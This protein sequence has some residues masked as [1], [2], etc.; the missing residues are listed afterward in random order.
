MR[1]HKLNSSLR[2]N[3]SLRLDASTGLSLLELGLVMA[4]VALALVPMVKSIGGPMSPNGKGSAA[5]TTGFKNKE[6]I[7]ATNL[8]NQV[9]SGDYSSFNCLPAGTGTN[10]ALP[11]SVRSYNR[12]EATQDNLTYQWSAM[13]INQANSGNKPPDGYSFFKGVLNIYE[14]GASPTNEPL[15]SM[16]VNFYKFTGLANQPQQK[17]GVLIALDRSGSMANSATKEGMPPNISGDQKTQKSLSF[18]LPFLWYRYKPFPTP[19]TVTDWGYDFP[20]ISDP[21][22][23]PLDMWNNAT[24]D[25]VSLQNM[26]GQNGSDPNPA[27]PFNESY[28]G[29]NN[30]FKCDMPADSAAWLAASPFFDKR[31]AY[32]FDRDWVLEGDAESKYAR[33][34]YIVPFCQEKQNLQQWSQVVNNKFSRFEAA[35]TAA[36]SLL[37]KLEERPSVVKAIKIGYFPWAFAPALLYGGPLQPAVVRTD[38]QGKPH[39]VF[40]RIRE[41]MLWL[42]RADPATKNSSFAVGMEGATNIHLALKEAQQQ[43]LADPSIQRRII[44]LMTDGEPAPNQAPNSNG[45]FGSG[46]LRDFAQ[47]QLGC[48]APKNQRTTLF[49]VGLIQADEALTRDMADATPNGQS[50]FARDIASLGPIFDS[51]A[52]EIQKL[53]LLSTA[54]RYGLDLS[55]DENT[56]GR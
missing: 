56:C 24:L 36:L 29:S 30:L 4:I 37:L 12:C 32:I 2:R 18:A 54:D 14:K 11:S 8:A 17:T 53:A 40:D 49:A 44:V 45:P 22:A 48:G 43:L 20:A 50:F 41:K 5:Q 26:A 9:L 34:N 21:V 52:Y 15:L 19:G 28:L 46:G 25:L 7:L 6:S 31:L 23:Q 1:P 16:P 13:P 47:S 33:Q 27:T 55:N 39:V 51:V 35:R 38:R 42:N 10:I 3:S